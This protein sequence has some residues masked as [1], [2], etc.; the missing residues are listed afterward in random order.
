LTPTAAGSSRASKPTPTS[1]SSSSYRRGNS[2]SL[3]GKH[4]QDVL[5]DLYRKEIDVDATLSS[6]RK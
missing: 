1:K 4:L 5:D 2:I 6:E 3:E